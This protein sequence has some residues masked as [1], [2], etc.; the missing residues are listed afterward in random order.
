MIRS[1]SNHQM[2]HPSST[3]RIAHLLILLNAIVWLSFG[4]IIAIGVHP[5]YIQP[6]VIRWVMAISALLAA[7]FL[8]SLI[9][10][11]RKRN[12]I[13]YWVTVIVLTAIALATILD[14]FGLVDLAFVII[15]ILPLVLLLR[16]RNW[17]LLPT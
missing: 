15:T 12:H 11:L 2:N 14:Q 1:E 17:H 16:D 7:V 5:S 13:A 10:L 9:V 8:F 6:T 4:I 3:I